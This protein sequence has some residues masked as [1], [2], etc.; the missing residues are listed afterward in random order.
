MIAYS[1]LRT[2]LRPVDAGEAN[3]DDNTKI[4]DAVCFISY[5]FRVGPR[6]YCLAFIDDLRTLAR[7]AA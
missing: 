2:S 3:G 1:G 7:L 5:V 6:P 4:G